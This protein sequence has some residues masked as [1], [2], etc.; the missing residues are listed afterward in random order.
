MWLG[1]VVE[2]SDREAWVKVVSNIVWVEG[3]ERGAV[4]RPMWRRGVYVY[5]GRGSQLVR[6][7]EASNWGGLNARQGCSGAAA[8]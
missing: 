1:I 4:L 6:E 3:E 2:M 8:D 5:S 7:R